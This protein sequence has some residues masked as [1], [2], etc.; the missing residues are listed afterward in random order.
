MHVY[1]NNPDY[2]HLPETAE[3]K[4]L[5]LTVA[6]IE[7]LIR[8]DHYQ[9]HFTDADDLFADF[10]TQGCLTLPGRFNHGVHTGVWGKLRGSTLHGGAGS[11]RC[12]PGSRPQVH[13]PVRV[14][15]HRRQ[16][17]S[18]ALQGFTHRRLNP[19]RGAPRSPGRR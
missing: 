12:L 2:R 5:A 1:S 3:G 14:Q 16:V 17:S 15:A 13:S 19:D 8:L 9:P 11:G 18:A 6:L 10:S 7:D 4:G